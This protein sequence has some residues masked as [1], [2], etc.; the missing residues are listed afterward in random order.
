LETTFRRAVAA[1]ADA[2]FAVFARS[3][4]DR[5]RRTG[6]PEADNPWTDVA[7]QRERLRPLFA[8]LAATAERCWVA[9]QGGNLVGY[10]RATV[11]DGLRELT[12]FFVLPAA[13]GRGVGRELLARAFPDDGSRRSVIAT[14][15]PRA[16]A[17]YLQTGVA[18]RGLAYWIHGAPRPLDVPTD[19]A[20]DPLPPGEAP[21]VLAAID[22]AVLGFSRDADHA[23]LTGDRSC[24]VCRRGDRAVG[25]AYV[26]ADA[27]GPA[28]VLDPADI[29]AILG[30][31]EAAA[32]AR[33][34]ASFGAS[35]P[36]ANRAA[37][38]HLL[39]RGFRLEDFPLVLMG[40]GPEPAFDRYILTDPVFFL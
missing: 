6:L 37:V 2:I 25:Y 27:V 10:A 32:A 36:L 23:F 31:A 3:L 34:A 15:D 9:E 19:L 35:V 18:A 8:H 39:G 11:R 29:P 4:A 20:I 22:R 21:A 17:R 12:E 13:Q 5:L 16:L 14:T 1:D 38:G 40:D 7:A 26:G 33:G 24:W 30:R 28:A